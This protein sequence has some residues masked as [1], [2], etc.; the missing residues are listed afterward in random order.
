M[1][2]TLIGEVELGLWTVLQTCACTMDGPTKKALN[3]LIILLCSSYWY[4]SGRI[5]GSLLK[6]M[7]ALNVMFYPH[8]YIHSILFVLGL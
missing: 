1:V 7:V 2:N 8:E 6:L 3:E 5:K 4:L